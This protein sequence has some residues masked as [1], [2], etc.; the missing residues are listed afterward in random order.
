VEGALNQ[1]FSGRTDTDIFHSLS[2]SLPGDLASVSLHYCQHLQK[3]IRPEDVELLPEV[4]ATLSYF[5]A[6]PYRLS[7]LTGNFEQAARIKLQQVAIDHFFEWHLGAFGADGAQRDQLP[8]KALQRA[9]IDQRLKDLQAHEVWVIGDT[10]NDIACAKAHNMV[11]V[12]VSTGYFSAEELAKNEPDY[13]FDNLSM[14]R[15]ILNT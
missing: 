5:K 7:L 2:H 14:L 10:P 4:E 8:P 9:R 6:S 1:S 13:L 3:N 11:S 15:T 12:A